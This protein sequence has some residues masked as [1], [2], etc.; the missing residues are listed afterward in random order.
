MDLGNPVAG[1]VSGAG[2]LSRG[3]PPNTCRTSFPCSVA[4]SQGKPFTYHFEANTS[5]RRRR[6]CS[7]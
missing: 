5:I 4:R 2:V 7:P 1:L 3:I 6:S